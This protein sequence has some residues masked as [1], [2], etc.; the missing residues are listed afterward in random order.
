MNER[1]FLKPTLLEIEGVLVPRKV[2][3][4]MGPY[5]AADGEEVNLDTYWHRKLQAGEVEEAEPPVVEAAA[6]PTV[7]V[8]APAK[9]AKK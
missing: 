2:R 8:P 4:P 3:K 5:L 9:T 7:D 6:Q 1:I